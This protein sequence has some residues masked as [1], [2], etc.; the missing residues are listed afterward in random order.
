MATRSASSTATSGNLSFPVSP[1]SRRQSGG[2]A[3][4]DVDETAEGDG[5]DRL[6]DIQL[7]DDG[8]EVDLFLDGV[9][10]RLADADRRGV[11]VVRTDV[12]RA[13]VFVERVADG[14]VALR[15]DGATDL[16]LVTFVLVRLVDDGRFDVLEPGLTVADCAPPEGHVAWI[17]P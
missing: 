6:F 15:D 17:T 1:S 16:T 12:L 5:S 3:E 14:E 11:G 8:A 13:G 10:D 7:V 4:D 9:F 2:S